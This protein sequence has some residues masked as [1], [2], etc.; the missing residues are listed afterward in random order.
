MTTT[1]ELVTC[2]VLVVI[3]RSSRKVH[4]A[5]IT[6]GPD[7]AFMMQVGRNLTDPVDTR[8]PVKSRTYNPLE[9]RAEEGETP[10]PCY[11]YSFSQ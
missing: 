11:V 7:G 3:E 6:P 8:Q 10:P 1:I 5:G 2:Y 4:I 9:F